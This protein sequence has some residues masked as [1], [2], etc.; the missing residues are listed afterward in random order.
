M[1]LNEANSIQELRK[2]R[3]K[4][5]RIYNRA[6]YLLNHCHLDNLKHLRNHYILRQII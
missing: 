4:T 6:R 2:I 5:F 3:S 1:I